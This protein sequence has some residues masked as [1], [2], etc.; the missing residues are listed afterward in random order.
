[1][2][3]PAAQD[4]V[5]AIQLA[6]YAKLILKVTGIR[7][8]PQKRMLLSNRI[9]RRLKATGIKSYQAY[10]EQLCKLKVDDPEWDAFLEEITTHETYLFRDEAHWKWFREQ[11]IPELSKAAAGG[12]RKKELRIWSAACS[13]GDE[14]YTI[15]SCIANG[16]T[17]CSQWKIEIVGT[18][19]GV[20]A[21]DSAQNAKF[22]TRA[23]RLVPDGIRKRFFQKQGKE[24]IW[25]PKPELTR[26]TSFRQHNLLE[27]P[28]MKPF[29]LIILK[30]VLI[31][32]DDNAKQT[33]IEHLCKLLQPGGVF[34]TSAADNA[35]RYLL[36]ELDKQT[37][38]MFH[39]PELAK[40]SDSKRK[41]LV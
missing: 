36:T 33:T 22:G 35:A 1:M 2:A 24:D 26:W 28:K 37:P 32:F 38:W 19:I 11:Y 31:Y 29:D 15:A 8:S 17:N 6:N 27:P 4:L 30:N 20:G 21:V 12:K 7:V 14:A 25:V 41:A 9:R 16:L 3:I 13:T 10:Y 18:D 40:T 39:K 23:M 34:I 5:T